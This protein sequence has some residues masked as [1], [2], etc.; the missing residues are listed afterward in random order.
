MDLGLNGLRALVAASSEGLGYA[1]ALELARE[2]A[3]VAINSRSIDKLEAAA[4][5]IEQEA[6]TQV[7]TLA[8]DLSDP[9]APA[10]LVGE[11]AAALGGMD[12]L[13]TNSGGPPSGRFDVLSEAD[14]MHSL[15]LVFH[16]HRRLIHAALP[17]LR[18]SAHASVL[19]I[20]SI[21]VKQPIPNLAPSNAGRHATIGLTKTLA[22]ELGPEG[23][24]FNSI[25][26]SYTETQRVTELMEKR[27][28]EKGTSV[29]EELATTAADSP[30]GR[31]GRPDEFAK[32]AAFLV[33]PAASYITGVMLS[34]DGGLYKGTV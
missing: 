29:E 10:Q 31:M 8:A 25:L 23:I 20:T 19:T 34:V 32:A 2:G 12:I 18:A 14:W 3:Q 17:H 22:L 21:S 5:R 4:A 24:R 30:L 27:A 1:T 13:V 7:V 33:S 16:S 26:P 6:G 9:E 28:A 11:A 15:E